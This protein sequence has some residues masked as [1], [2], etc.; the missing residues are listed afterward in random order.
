MSGTA[1]R[2]AWMSS[3]LWCRVSRRQLLHCP[4]S[5]SIHDHV[6]D[7]RS[8][9]LGFPSSPCPESYKVHLI[10]HLKPACCSLPS[11]SSPPTYLP[12][13]E[14]TTSH[15]SPVATHST[16]S[17]PLFP[18]A[19]RRNN[20]STAFILVSRRRILPTSSPHSNLL[21]YHCPPSI[22]LTLPTAHLQPRAWVTSVTD[23]LS[24]LST[25]H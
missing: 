15:H 17:D 3:E 22:S 12:D 7:P 6:Q 25:A 18:A 14:P 8:S 4:V 10:P 16:T 11:P 9:R 5:M 1:P 19:C 20:Y 13:L 2:L 21:P 23:T 24:I